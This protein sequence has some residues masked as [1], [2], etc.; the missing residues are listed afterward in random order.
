MTSICIRKSSL[1]FRAKRSAVEKPLTVSEIF[2]D[3]STPVDMTETGNENVQFAL[4]RE[5]HDE[6]LYS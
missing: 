4:Q 5:Y 3:V 1:S 6:Y 2:R